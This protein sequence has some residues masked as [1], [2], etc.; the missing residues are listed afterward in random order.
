MVK[1]VTEND[2]EERSVKYKS[3]VVTEVTRDLHFYAQSADL[4]TRAVNRDVSWSELKAGG[5]LWHSVIYP[6]SQANWYSKFTS[7]VVEYN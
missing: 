5:N 4:G 6:Y 3:V 2:S 1:E 7:A